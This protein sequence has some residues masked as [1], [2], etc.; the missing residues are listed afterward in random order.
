MAQI[1]HTNDY[2]VA[3]LYKFVRLS[4]LEDW[5]Q[6]LRAVTE[7]CQMMGTILLADEGINGTV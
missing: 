5:Q 2:V 4:G 3:A 7:S 6:R 1:P